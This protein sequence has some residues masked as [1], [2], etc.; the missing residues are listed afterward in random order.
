VSTASE[1]HGLSVS[2]AAWHEAVTVAVGY[3]WTRDPFDRLIAATAAI[4][5][6]KL[7]TADKTLRQ[8][9]PF[10]CWR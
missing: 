3:R 9:C 6:C 1:A 10:A 7:V 4:E 5:N 8:H 2:S